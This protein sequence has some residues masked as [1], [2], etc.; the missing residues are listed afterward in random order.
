[1]VIPLLNIPQLYESI[2][3]PVDTPP[4]VGPTLP[5]ISLPAYSRENYSALEVLLA[6][7]SEHNYRLGYTEPPRRLRKPAGLE[8]E[9]EGL[10]T[11]AVVNI[12][13]GYLAPR[14]LQPKT[15]K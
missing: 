13:Q 5:T 14:H 10:Q 4:L 8:L 6:E 2:I 15:E 1:M 12:W 11:K 7:D 9:S 3:V